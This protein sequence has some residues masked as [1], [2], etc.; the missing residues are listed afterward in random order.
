LL[1]ANANLF[2]A[3]PVPVHRQTADTRPRPGRDFG[4]FITHSFGRAGMQ[5]AHDVFSRPAAGVPKQT[6]PPYSF[7]DA[8][9]FR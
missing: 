8:L 1:A 6:Q 9:D 3:P 2:T 4:A 5:E 7:R